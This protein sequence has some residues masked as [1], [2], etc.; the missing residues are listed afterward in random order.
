MKKWLGILLGMALYG[1]A[2]AT[3]AQVIIIRHG[4]KPK[5]GNELSLKGWE[6]AHALIPFFQGNKKVLDFGTPVAIYAQKPSTPESSMRPIETVQG[7]ADALN[8][9]LNTNF[10]HAQYPSMAQEILSNPDYEG[11]MV[12]I[13]WE[14][15]VIPD[16]AKNLNAP[17]V[18]NKWDGD[19][20]D[21]LWVITYGDEIT[22]D[23]LPQKLLYGDSKK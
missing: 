19:D 8:L 15:K 1:T 13:C 14:H 3:P 9:T 22:F 4:E 7:L 16:I 12:L 5:E 6:R 20:F 11:K 23:D 17:N 21:R 18:P 10:E 2:F